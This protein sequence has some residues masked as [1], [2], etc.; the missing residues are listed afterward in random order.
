MKNETFKEVIF[1]AFVFQE[2]G[3]LLID[4]L[5]IFHCRCYTIIIQE[6][7][8]TPFQELFHFLLLLFAVYQQ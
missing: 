4:R 8:F 2:F 6:L 7:I 3:D 1:S 5:F